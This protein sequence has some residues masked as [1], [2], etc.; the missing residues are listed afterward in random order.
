MYP[1]TR[2][3]MTYML[4]LTISL[5]ASTLALPMLEPQEGSTT[6]RAPDAGIDVLSKRALSVSRAFPQDFP[7]PSIFLDTDTW[8]AFSTSSGGLNV[9]VA[10]SSDA[11]SW[12]L[13]GVDALPSVG[14]WADADE[15]DVWAPDVV[16][17]DAGQY[18][19]FYSAAV[20]GNTATHCIGVATSSKAQGPYEPLAEPFACP[21][22]Q[23]GAIDASGFRDTDDNLYVV[24]KI[25][26]NSIG[27]VSF[28]P[29]HSQLIS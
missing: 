16:I 24:Y 14:A 19:L 2:T 11:T 1:H 29:A 15:P 28:A 21:Q 10:K 8:Y 7:D 25:D 20:S 12:S 22:S 9:P 5:A 18:V 17:T 27:H 6:R 23:G 26:G 13:L 3:A 4:A